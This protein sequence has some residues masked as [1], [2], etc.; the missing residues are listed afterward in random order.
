MPILLTRRPR[1]R[2]AGRVL[3]LLCGVLTWVLPGE[4]SIVS[5]RVSPLLFP[6]LLSL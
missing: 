1:L 4:D 5:P 6:V 2:E 3:R